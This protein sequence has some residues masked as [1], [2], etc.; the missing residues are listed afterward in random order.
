MSASS[1]ER[2]KQVLASYGADPARWPADERA[3]LENAF[4]RTAPEDLPELAE[5]REI[6]A[7]LSAV[8]EVSVPDAALARILETASEY[9]KAEIVQFGER[10]AARK[11]V[12]DTFRLRD[13]L[14]LGAALAASLLLG[15]F[16][17]LDEQ[18]GSF[19]VV[20]SLETVSAGL[21]DSLWSFDPFNLSNGEPL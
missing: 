21:E 12:F 8:P 11:S 1:Q 13:A 9:P 6:D 14:P 7:V 16:A 17:G 20:A 10:K 3:S 5:A 2:L 18:V 4:H 15:V 19:A